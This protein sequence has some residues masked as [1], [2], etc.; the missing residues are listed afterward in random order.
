MSEIAVG[1]AT[2]ISLAMAA[3]LGVYQPRRI[4]G[5]ARVEAGEQP[6]VFLT[7]GGVGLICWGGA[8]LLAAS[9]FSQGA[10]AAQMSHGRLVLANGLIDVTSLAAMLAATF[11]L[12]PMG[13]QRTG[14]GFNQL[15]AG[16][17]GGFVSIVVVLPLIFWVETGSEY[18]WTLLG[19]SHPQ[20]H[21]L[22]LILSDAHSIW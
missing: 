11:R 5:P 21:V 13:L 20:A 15:P 18:L 9:L 8:R 7:I 4:N 2:G 1:I 19:Q 10:P 16:L 12:R 3:L 22:L 14:V 17:M 6:N